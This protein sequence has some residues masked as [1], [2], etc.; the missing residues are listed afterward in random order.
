MNSSAMANSHEF[1]PQLLWGTVMHRRLRPVEHAFHYSVFFVR[2][3]LQKPHEA[4]RGRLFAFNRKGLLSVQARDHGPRDGSD[5]WTWAQTQLAQQGLPTGG[6]VVLQT[7][8]RV[9]GYAFNPVS[10]WFCHDPEGRL[11]AVMAEVNNTFG[12]HHAY[13][14]SI[15]DSH[16]VD[17]HTALEANKVF[18]VSPFCQVQGHYQFWFGTNTQTPWSRIDYHDDHGQLMITSISG[19]SHGWSV[20][21]LLKALLR[22][23]LLGLGVIG[24]IHWQALRLYLR[25]VPFYGA[26]PT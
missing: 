9:L 15:P 16:Q 14:L 21:T 18:H 10:F 5:L 1:G 2:I 6:E 11:V 25:R 4:Q 13:W 7:F 26:R 24:R 20:S 3:P 22:M 8:P 23:P 19:K 17:S 12:G